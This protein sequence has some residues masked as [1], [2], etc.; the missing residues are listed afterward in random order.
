M[1]PAARIQ[2]AI[3]ILDTVFEG[4]RPADKVIA[5]YF[6]LR[7]YAGSKDRRGIN[8]EV[9]SVL[10]SRARLRWLAQQLDLSQ[11]TRI[12]VLINCVLQDQD[13]E[14][15]FTGEQYA[16]AALKGKETE[17]PSLLEKE[18][19]SQAPDHIRMEYP[20]WLDTDLKTSLGDDFEVV[21]KS[22]NEEAPLDLRINTLHPDAKQAVNELSKQN[23]ETE[24]GLYSPV[25]LRSMKKAKL[26]GLK[27]YKEGLIDVQDEGSQ[28]ISLLSQAKGCD[29]VMDFCAGGG[30]K[31]LALA[32]EMENKGDLYALDISSTRLYKM[33]RRLER[34]QVSN[35]ILNPI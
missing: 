29:L 27:A 13:I 18:D 14:L 28:L 26:G 24:A 10:R 25:C 19:I 34:A 8:A 23:I 35:V 9:Y 15:L 11:T 7:R 30:G 3:E 16:P 21:L 5:E 2:S 32:A 6:K 33:K 12:L 17:L 1:K 20:K 22:L 4:K 31:T